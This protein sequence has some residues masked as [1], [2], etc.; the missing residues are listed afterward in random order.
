[1]KIPFI[2]PAY[3]LDSPN[4]NCQTSLG[5]Y[6]EVDE[7]HQGKNVG[8][9]RGTPGLSV[10]AT[11]PSS[12]VLGLWTGEGRLFAVAGTSP[13]H[14]YEVFADGTYT[15]HNS[16]GNAVLLPGGST[17]YAPAL[18]FPNASGTQLMV[19][20]G[21]LVWVDTGT[22]TGA[23]P[24]VFSL[25]LT[26]LQIDGTG[27]GLISGAGFSSTDIG[28]TIV[29]QS[30]I[31][32]TIQDQVIVSVTDGVAAGSVAWGTANST[33]GTGIEYLGEH[34]FT[35][36]YTLSTP[37]LVGSNSYSFNQT[38]VGR[39]LTIT[40]GSGW[41]LGNYVIN[42]VTGAAGSANV[43]ILSAAP[44]AANA[45]GGQA[46]ELVNS[47]LAA[48][49]GTTLDT[50]GI[51]AP[52]LSNAWYISAPDDFTSWSPIDEADK[53]AYP[54]HI[55]AFLADHELLWIF[56]DLESTEIWWDS[57]SANFPFQRVQSGGVIHY[58]LV[59][60]FSPVQ[61]AL[62][63]VAWL[64]WNINRG[65]PQAVYAQGLVPQRISTHAIEQ[66]WRSYPTVQDAIGY[67]Y[68]EDGHEFWVMHFPSGDATW[69]YDF[70]ASQQAGIPMWHQPMWWDGTW[71]VAPTANTVG[72]PNLHRQLQRSHAYGF[73]YAHG[74]ASALPASHLVGDHASGNI[75]I[76]ALTNLSDNGQAIFR[77]RA[78]AHL[79][80]ENLRAFDGLFTLDLE[81]GNQDMAVTFDYSRDFGHTFIN[82]KT[83]A[84]PA[85]SNPDAP[86]VSGY[87]TRMLWRR[88]GNARDLVPR[89]TCYSIAK[90]SF[91][92][93]FLQDNQGVS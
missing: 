13:A 49:T 2:G 3:Q 68:T 89:I 8:R 71:A 83:I 80:Q 27:N 61:L 51:I 4:A 77:Q 21:G 46:T 12:N 65:A 36:L 22:G 18:I 5:L 32:F 57:G 9:I 42:G 43:A 39:T 45:S 62:N 44:A 59:A 55:L 48:G 11:L 38:D 60:Q 30:G 70:T 23:Q 14:L 16:V 19:I 34:L 31:G 88:L 93:G 26:G 90:I 58:G 78:F 91:T 6:V 7:T 84:A 81:V 87:N 76:Q 28:S 47:Q 40:G 92:D 74:S 15:D 37:Y 73:L 33:G 67:S 79:S 69:V 64:A 66:I 35:D 63:G 20:H 54:D 29:I 24:I 17:E 53:E 82:A 56:G 25:A 85:A 75:Y 86:D 1:M 10:L 41:T 50:Y 72:V 52:P